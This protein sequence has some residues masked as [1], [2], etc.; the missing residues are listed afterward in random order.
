MLVLIVRQP[1][2]TLA[3]LRICAVS[4][5]PL[6]HFL[7]SIVSINTLKKTHKK[8]SEYDQEIPQSHTANPEKDYQH[9]IVIISV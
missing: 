6:L 7:A 1:V 9:K 3:S 8:V 5:E 4:P 2:K